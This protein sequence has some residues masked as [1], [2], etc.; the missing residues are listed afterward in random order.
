MFAVDTTSLIISTA[1]VLF[2]CAFLRS[3]VGFG[4]ALLGIPLLGMVMSLP[5]AS[6]VV[7]FAGVTMSLVI[8]VANREKVD[9]QSAWRLALSSLAGIPFGVLLLHSAPERIVKQLLG[10]ILVFYGL[11]SLT[12]PRM[13]HLGRERYAFAFGFVAGILGGAYNTSGPPVIIYGTLRRWSPGYF[14][15]TLQLFFLFTYSAT[16]AGHGIAK[17]WTPWV[18]ELFLWALPGIGLGLY[19]GGKMHSLIPIRIFSPIILGILVIL[20]VLLLR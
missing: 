8:F 4:D 7:A 17:L 11:Y 12:A 15:A 19:L 14:R 16:I 18:L 10:L 9:F 2:L 20:G 6:P 5:T 3:A 1:A 13:P